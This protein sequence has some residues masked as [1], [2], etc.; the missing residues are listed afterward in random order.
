M[1]EREKMLAGQLYNPGDLEL[2][3]LHQR[4]GKLCRL[5]NA[6]P[7]EDEN[8]L[9]RLCASLLGGIGDGRPSFLTMGRTPLSGRGSTPIPAW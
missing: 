2:S 1:T 3:Q 7:V 4:A 6:T 5:Y 8:T 9:G